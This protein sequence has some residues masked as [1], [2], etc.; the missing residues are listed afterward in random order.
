MT[1]KKCVLLDMKCHHEVIFTVTEMLD[2]CLKQSL[3]E[4]MSLGSSGARLPGSLLFH[5]FLIIW[6]Y[7]PLLRL[8]EMQP[9]A[10][11]EQE[12]AELSRAASARSGDGARAVQ[13]T[14]RVS[15]RV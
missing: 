15:P 10:L 5:P 7:R 1:I 9:I 11:R 13:L 6:M 2:M 4:L 12:Q 14:A 3:D 8:S